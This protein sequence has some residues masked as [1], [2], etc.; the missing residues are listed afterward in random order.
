MALPG[1]VGF[2]DKVRVPA[3]PPAMVRRQRLLDRLHTQIDHRLLLVSAPGGYGKT[4]L[5]VDF[6]SDA[7]FPVA[8]YTLEGADHDLRSFAHYLA[9]A[10]REQFPRFG[11]QTLDLVTANPDRPLDVRQLVSTVTH[12][13]EQQVPSFFALVHDD[14]H[15]VGAA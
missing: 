10:I 4:T 6:A 1:P 13:I 9:L 3:R 7:G 12:E 8:W 15:L 2:T 11:A 14:Y 5:L